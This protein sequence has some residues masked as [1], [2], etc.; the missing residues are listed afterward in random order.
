VAF[1]A[2]RLHGIFV[3]FKDFVF[4]DALE[5]KSLSILT[6]T[7]V[8]VMYTRRPPSKVSRITSYNIYTTE[9]DIRKSYNT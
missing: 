3:T 6:P 5:G 2:A 8:T 1:R 4:I 7:C 9:Y